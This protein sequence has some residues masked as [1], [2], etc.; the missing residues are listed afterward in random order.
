MNHYYLMNKNVILRQFDVEKDVLGVD[1]VSHSYYTYG[2]KTQMPTGYT[3]MS[4]W[5]SERNYAKHK[6]HFKKWLKEWGIDTL[7]GFID[8]THCLSL[9]DTLWVKPCNSDLSWEQVNLYD[10]HF[11]DVASKTAFDNGLY[12]LA[13]S[14]TSPEFTSDGSFPKC[15]VK[16][17][18]GIFL[19]KGGLEGAS[20]VG[21]EPISEVISSEIV[22]ELLSINSISSTKSVQYKLTNQT[23]EKTYNKPFSKCLCF[24]NKDVAFVPFSL[25]CREKG[26]VCHSISDVIDIVKKN[27]KEDVFNDVINMFIIDS[28]T[29]NQDRHLSNFGF[30]VDSDTYEIEQLAPY[31]DF[32]FSMLTN[33]TAEDLKNVEAYMKTY[34]VG[35]KLGGDFS[36]IGKALIEKYNPNFKCDI[37]FPSQLPMDV[38]CFSEKPFN[39]SLTEKLTKR[40]PLLKEAFEK[41]LQEIAEKKTFVIENSLEEDCIEYD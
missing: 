10:N 8:A 14:T 22:R 7:T 37:E 26:I 2:A 19:Y 4:D 31:Y 32:N 30:L 5:L 15:W 38:S 16:E 28:I 20:N 1:K 18:N 33:A 3:T 21:L 6:E 25:Y 9:N 17:D 24:T 35:H 40:M 34:D 11:T 39:D 23:K 12:G 36:T 41:N 29:M 27:C 13:L